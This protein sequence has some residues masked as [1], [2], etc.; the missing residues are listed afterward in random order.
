MKIQ[1]LTTYQRRRFNR[2]RVCPFCNRLITDSESLSFT[3]DTCGHRKF[4]HFYHSR[5]SDEQTIKET[6]IKKEND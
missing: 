2:N 5:C 4:Y 3:T 1:E 6:S